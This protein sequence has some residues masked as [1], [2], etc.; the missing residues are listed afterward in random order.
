MDHV[1]YKDTLLKE[2][3]VG[4]KALFNRQQLKQIMNQ[5]YALEKCK[6]T[7]KRNA[8]YKTTIN[9]KPDEKNNLSYKQAKQYKLSKLIHKQKTTNSLGKYLKEKKSKQEQ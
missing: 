9:Y 2:G 1:T 6:P 8:T 7:K 5:I 3:N 4:K